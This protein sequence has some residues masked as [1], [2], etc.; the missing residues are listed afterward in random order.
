MTIREND[1]R[2][3]PSI[4]QEQEG[5]VGTTLSWVLVAAVAIGALAV[6]LS[7]WIL[8]EERQDVDEATT[9]PLHAPERH[10]SVLE[11]GSIE[12]EA[13]GLELHEEARRKLDS[14]SWVDRDSQIVA[15][16][17]D[18]AMDWVVRDARSGDRATD[19]PLQ[20]ENRE[21]P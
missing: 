9:G 4:A 6:G 13:P 1:Q 20:D 18:H 3:G 15:I 5:V 11:H 16:P 17:I 2:E 14:F 12:R 7:A 8:Q 21:G 19:A 10:V